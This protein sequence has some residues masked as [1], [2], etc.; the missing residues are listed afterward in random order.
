MSDIRTGDC[1]TILPTLEKGSVQ[2][3][4]TSPPYFGLRSYGVGGANGEIGLEETPDAYVAALVEVFRGVRDVL[5][6]DGTVWLNLGDSYSGGGPHHGDANTGK[7]GTNRGSI[8]GVDRTAIPGLKPKDLVGIPWRVAFA[9]QADGWYLRSDIIWHKP[10]VMPESVTDRPTKSHEYL[11]LLSKKATYYYDADAIKEPAVGTNDHD[12]TGTGYDAPGQTPAKGNRATRLA[13][14]RRIEASGGV[15]SGGVENL[16]LGIS[17]N[18]T[19]NRRS[20]WT[21]NTVPN[22]EEHFA[23]FPPAL[24]EP[25]IMAG[26]SEGGVCTTCGRQ[27]VRV[28][29]RPTAPAV[30]PSTLDRFGT[31]DA[32][33][34]RKIG[35]QYQKWLDAN[36]KQTTGWVKECG[37]AGDGVRPSIVL[38]PFFGTGTVGRVAER[39]GR[40]WIGIE[41]SEPYSKI[42]K[43]RTAQRGLYS[44]ARP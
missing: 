27:L 9:L 4:V 8:T 26:A 3:C 34:H 18:G 11:F 2:C 39:L 40:R 10:N 29:E 1:R 23:A 36:P 16:S 24:V 25:C 38:D 41:L 19:R 44:E 20:V 35:G 28:T 33:V 5:A 7:S 13:A 21:I 15:L 22:Q 43:R 37:C 31:G 14:A 17:A 6:D 42:A 12:L 30:D 32:G